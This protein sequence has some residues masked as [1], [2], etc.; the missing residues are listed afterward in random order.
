[1]LFQIEE[2]DGSPIG[3]PDGPGAAVGIDLAAPQALVAVAVGGNAEVLTA[4]DG[5]PGPE[6]AALRDR[7][8]RFEPA[9]TAA[10]LL[11]LRGCAERTLGRP[12]THAAVAVAGALDVASN[13]AL[14][15]AAVASGLVITRVLPVAEA[16]TLGGG[17]GPV[18]AVAHGAAI[19]AED[20]AAALVR[21]L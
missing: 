18:H 17:A 8:G 1:M 7:A 5:S 9:A 10:A 6:T 14:K 4:R 16:A 12:V 15:E 3:E 21:G 2:P 11:V 19:A 20:D 13:A